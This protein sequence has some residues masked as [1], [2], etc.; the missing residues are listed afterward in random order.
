MRRPRDFLDRS[1]R[2]LTQINLQLTSRNRWPGP[3]RAY[4][5]SSTRFCPIFHS[6]ESRSDHPASP[7]VFGT[8]RTFKIPDSAVANGKGLYNVQVNFPVQ[9]KI[10]L[11][12]SDATGLGSGGT[13]LV[14]EVGPSIS[15]RSCNTTDPGVDFA[16]NLDSALTQC[17]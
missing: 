15:R 1:V 4:F 16:F 2:P 14:T 13:S 8:P 7:Q 3:L 9:Q 12:M 17:R 5:S 6:R 10:L 11:V